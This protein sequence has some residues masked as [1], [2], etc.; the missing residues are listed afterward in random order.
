MLKV[1][2]L[3]VWCNNTRLNYRL[4]K[5]ERWKEDADQNPKIEQKRGICSVKLRIALHVGP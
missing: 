5:G 1:M 2:L 4:C 3:F